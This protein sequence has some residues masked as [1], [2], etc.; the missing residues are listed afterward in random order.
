MLLPR[1]KSSHSEGLWVVGRHAQ[2]KVHSTSGTQG[3]WPKKSA[4]ILLHLLKNAESNAE[5][6]GLEVDLNVLGQVLVE[7]G[8]IED[9]IVNWRLAV[10]GELSSVVLR[11]LALVGW[12]HG[13]RLCVSVS[14]T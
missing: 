6:K 11:L 10:D 9:A 3:R 14:S 12:C 1:R 2:A 5:Y 7:A 4:E 13:T 8:N